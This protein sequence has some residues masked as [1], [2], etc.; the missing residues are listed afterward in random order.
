MIWL[1]KKFPNFI[2][3]DFLNHRDVDGNSLIWFC[4]CHQIL[5]VKNWL[6]E[7]DFDLYQKVIIDRD[8]NVYKLNKNGEELNLE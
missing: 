6:I 3:E 8:G 2:K 1:Q 7:F 5:K 4:A